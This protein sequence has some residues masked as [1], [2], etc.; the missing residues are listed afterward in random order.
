[1]LSLLLAWPLLP[2]LVP[3]QLAIW[4]LWLLLWLRHQWLS[5]LLLLP[6]QLMLCAVG[7]LS[8]CLSAIGFG[9]CSS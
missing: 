4:L 8:L 9:P 6:V 3:L 2:V 5:W 1:L 7:N